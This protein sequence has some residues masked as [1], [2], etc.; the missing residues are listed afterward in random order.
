MASPPGQARRDLL[1][2]SPK[3][4]SNTILVSHI[5]GGKDRAEWMHLELM[6]TIVYAP[7]EGKPIPVA[8]IRREAWAVLAAFASLP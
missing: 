5:H 1:G 6:E 4:G 8:R 7:N 3:P 2:M